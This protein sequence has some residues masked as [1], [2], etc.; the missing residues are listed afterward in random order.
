MKDLRL[1]KRFGVQFSYLLDCVDT[2]IIGE[3]ATDNRQKLGFSN[4]PK[5]GSQFCK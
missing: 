3:N 4:D 2:E 5:A 1:D